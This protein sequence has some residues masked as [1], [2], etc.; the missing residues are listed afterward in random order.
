MGGTLASRKAR[1]YVDPPRIDAASR[2]TLATLRL[3]TAPLL[4]RWRLTVQAVLGPGVEL[5]VR[6][7]AA[8]YREPTGTCDLQAMRDAVKVADGELQTTLAYA[9]M[10]LAVRQDRRVRGTYTRKRGKR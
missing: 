6:R 7:A 1:A 9:C 10:S 5:H 4:K 2:R 8:T 3:R